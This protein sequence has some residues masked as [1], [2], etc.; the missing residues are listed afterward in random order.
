MVFICLGEVQEVIYQYGL[1]LMAPHFL[2][3]VADGVMVAV[4]VQV[5]FN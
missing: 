4:M 3:A 1:N 5:I 2:A